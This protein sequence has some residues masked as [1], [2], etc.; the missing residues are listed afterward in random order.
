ME[1]IR[2]NW[3]D[4]PH[5]A[6]V[7]ANVRDITERKEAEEALKEIRENE[8]RRI[9]RDLH[10]EALQDLIH[11]L[12]EAQ[13]AR[14]RA[15]GGDLN[16]AEESFRD[17]LEVICETL[18]NSVE[19]LREAIFELRLRE[20]LEISVLASMEALVELNRRMSRKRYEISL[21]VEEGFPET[22]PAETGGELVR[23]VQEALNNARRHSGARGIRVSLERGEGDDDLLC[24]EVA[25]DGRGFDTGSARGGVGTSAMRRRA[26]DLGGELEIES[27]PGAGTVVRFCCPADR[28][29]SGNSSVFEDTTSRDPRI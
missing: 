2:S 19:G 14:L 22:L 13:L 10:D 3:L 9:A 23:I 27:Q 26:L 28:L 18:Q 20:N 12:Q 4:D 16:D 21:S 8:R 11:G 1:A 25:D 7:V 17:S 15:A 6:G 24:A 29:S 5:I